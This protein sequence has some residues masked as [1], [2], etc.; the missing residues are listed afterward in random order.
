MG[1]GRRGD[2]ESVEEEDE[3]TYVERGDSNA[4]R[5]KGIAFDYHGNEWVVSKYGNLSDDKEIGLFCTN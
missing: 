3:G 4:K 1:S 2:N 5:K